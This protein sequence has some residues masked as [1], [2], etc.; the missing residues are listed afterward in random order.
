MKKYIVTITTIATGTIEKAVFAR[1]EYIGYEA[2]G[3]RWRV[4]K[5]GARGWEAT[6]A[7][8][9]PGRWTAA[10]IQRKTLAAVAEALASRNH[11]P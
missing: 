9:H 5:D 7:A 11:Q 6:P 1:G 2:S 4:R 8:N 3:A 10:R